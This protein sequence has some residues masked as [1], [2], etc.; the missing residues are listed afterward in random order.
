[1]P[2]KDKD[3]EKAEEILST[4]SEITNKH[5]D[6][7]RKTVEE[8]SN[9]P[10]PTD[11]EWTDYVLKQFTDRETDRE[12][13][14]KA[15]GLR[16]VAELLL[17][18]FDIDTHVVQ[19]PTFDSGATVVVTLR[20]HLDK[21][22]ISGAADVSSAN[23]DEN[24][25]VHSVA[26][27]ETRAEGRALKKALRLTKVYTAEEMQGAAPDEPLGVDGRAPTSMINM[28]NMMCKK[29]NIDLALFAKHALNVNSMQD[30][31]L[32]QGRELN[33]QL[34]KYKKEGVPDAIK[35]F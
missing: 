11:P 19:T 35:T 8:L 29:Q 20:F 1:M 9:Q 7:L 16:R 27:A 6:E 31:T 28:L 4:A 24:F 14:P 18:P 25:A 13:R 12:G 33:N 3:I 23:T 34:F 22:Q 26:T 10:S 30:L 17:G 15:D 32:E 21:R 5:M 2:K